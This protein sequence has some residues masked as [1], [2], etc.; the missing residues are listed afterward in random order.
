[1]NILIIGSGA[2]EHAISMAMARSS[3]Q[4]ALFCYGS[5]IN[6][7]IERLCK[8]YRKG[9]IL[10][11]PMIVSQA[12]NWQI[13]LAI[14]GPEAPLEVGLADA[15][16]VASI[17]VIGPRQKLARIESSKSYARKLMDE[18]NIPGNPM[19]KSFKTLDGIESFLHEL[20][21][22]N[23]V[24]KA[25]GLMGGK[26]VKLAGEH[27]KSYQEALDWCADIIAQDHSILIEEKLIGQEFSLI[28]FCDGIR[29]V[30]M[31]IIQDH[32][33]AYVNDQGPNTG[34]M[35]SYSDVNHSLP[36][37][38][39][40][41]VAEALEINQAMLKAVMQR[42]GL[43]YIGFLYGSFMATKK[44]IYVIEFNARLGDPEALNVLSL[45]E[46]D[47]LDICQAMVQ[48]RLNR[49]N[50]E[51]AHKA[52]V[53]KYVVPKGYPDH[54]V[55]NIPIDVSEI[56]DDGHLFFAA[57]DLQADGQLL[58]T[59]SRVAAYVGIA[60]NLTVAEQIAES[61]IQLIK[62]DIFH[63]EDI[64]TEKLI[65]A[66]IEEMNALRT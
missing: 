66:R 62:G 48:G 51:F 32:K 38:T 46:S 30:P 31:P 6:P 39:S 34:G 18:H 13:D 10:D 25:D 11:S 14:I 50:I 9:D 8:D 45:L 33:R 28:C 26:G 4:K 57:V 43:P 5:S 16:K 21:E 52:T 61:N 41:E 1:M 55:K 64:G 19:A 15:F 37:L 65:A 56:K 42:E 54:P 44:G 47:F 60:D 36:F 29:A 53:C 49:L 2:R 63:R 23:Y 59:G 40:D 35:G 17:P 20:G 27:L 12:L 22:D 24:I 7:G 58:A 3:Q